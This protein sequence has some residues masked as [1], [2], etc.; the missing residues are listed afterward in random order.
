MIMNAAT[1]FCFSRRG[2]TEYTVPRNSPKLYSAVMSGSK[3]TAVM[4][5]PPAANAA[6]SAHACGTE[7]SPAATGKK[8]LLTLSMSSS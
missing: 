4:A 7:S 6:H 5:T 3:F 2:G 8:G 1:A